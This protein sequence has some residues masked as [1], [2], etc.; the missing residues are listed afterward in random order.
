MCFFLILIDLWTG[1]AQLYFDLKLWD[2][3]KPLPFDSSVASSAHCM[4]S[5]S[6]ECC[7][8]KWNTKLKKRPRAWK[9]DHL[10]VNIHQSPASGFR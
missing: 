8:G 1:V 9:P 6:V 3:W 5:P 2:V 7:V 10:S 4:V